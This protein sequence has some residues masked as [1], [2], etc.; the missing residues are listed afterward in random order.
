M[1]ES[2]SHFWWRR[3]LHGVRLE[4]V[5]DGRRWFHALAV[6]LAEEGREEGD[7]YEPL[8]KPLLFRELAGLPLDDPAA[9]S[10]FATRWGFLRESRELVHPRRIDAP[11]GDFSPHAA[12]F[13]RRLE[14]ERVD[15]WREAVEAFKVT[16]AMW[17][18]LSSGEPKGLAWVV[19]A[20]QVPGFREFQAHLFEEIGEV[21]TPAQIRRAGWFLFNRD[22]N[23]MLLEL[24]VSPGL[25]FDA[26]TKG[27]ALRLRPASLLGATWLQLAEAADR[28]Y[29]ARHCPRC[30]DWFVVNPESRRGHDTYCSDACRMAAYRRR[31][32]SRE[33][34]LPSRQP[35][36]SGPG[37]ATPGG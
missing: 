19:Q 14:A 1:P 16:F 28:R 6:E 11:P 32:K 22:V 23:R 18:S 33:A 8:R 36:R 30:R 4:L 31:R 27:P 21:R 2:F 25:L 37:G 15:Q 26:R 10:G 5:T 20:L 29:S 7:V 17:A 12:D 35:S 3:P 24:G 13:S 9:W 34:R